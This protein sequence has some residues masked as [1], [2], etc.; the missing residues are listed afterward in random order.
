[1]SILTK[2]ESGSSF[3]LAIS[4][5]ALLGLYGILLRLVGG[6]SGGGRGWTYPLGTTGGGAGVTVVTGGAGEA[7]A[8]N[9]ALRFF[10]L[11]PGLSTG[12]ATAGI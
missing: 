1:M 6:R 3:N 9:S 12:V 8:E 7:E 4:S 11:F 10:D 5:F 2:N